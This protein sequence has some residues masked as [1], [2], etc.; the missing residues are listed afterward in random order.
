MIFCD[1]LG[2]KRPDNCLIAE[3]K[4]RKNITQETCPDR[5]P[6]PGLCVTGACYRQ[7]HSGGRDVFFT[8]PN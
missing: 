4:T 3:E 2:L 6:N 7:L 1:I 8:Y 5:G